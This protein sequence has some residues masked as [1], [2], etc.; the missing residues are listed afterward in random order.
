[1]HVWWATFAKIGVVGVVRWQCYWMRIWRH[2]W[3]E[4]RIV[5]EQQRFVSGDEAESVWKLNEIQHN[6]NIC[7]MLLFKF[8]GKHFFVSFVFRSRHPF[9]HSVPNSLARSRNTSSILTKIRDVFRMLFQV[10]IACLWTRN[11]NALQGTAPISSDAGC[12]RSSA[13]CILFSVS[14]IAWLFGRLF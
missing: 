2:W 1:M 12:S 10:C 8:S 7:E 4:N 6:L 3:D 9:F 11:N 5:S 13:I 14:P